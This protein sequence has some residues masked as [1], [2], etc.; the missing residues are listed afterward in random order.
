L[1]ALNEDRAALTPLGGTSEELA[2]FKGYGYATVVEIL[3]SA[4]QGGD[5][6]RLLTGMK[7]GKKVPYHIG[8]FFIAIN[9]SCFTELDEFKKTTGNILRDLRSSQKMPGHDRIY[10]AGEK[11]HLVWL[12][13]RDKGVPLNESLQKE[14][15]QLISDYGIEGFDFPF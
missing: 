9:I 13:R 8:H 2:G 3:S 1:R 4:L 11:E 7:D 5:Y 14:I 12:E 10:T 6:L 15:R